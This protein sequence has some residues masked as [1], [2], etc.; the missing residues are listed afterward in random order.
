MSF[1]DEHRWSGKIFTGEWTA[2]DGGTIPV[3]EPATGIEIGRVGEASLGDLQRS[4][5]RAR[6]AQTAWAAVSFTERAAVLRRAAELWTQHSAEV[7][8]WLMREAGGDPSEGA[9]RS[10]WG[11]AG[12]SGV[13]GAAL[14]RAGRGAA[15]RPGT[16][17]HEPAHPGGGGGRHRAVQH[18]AEAGDP[19]GG[20]R[21]GVGQRGDP[22]ARPAH[23][24][25]GWRGAGQGLRGGRAARR[26]AACAARRRR[27]GL[28]DGGPSRRQRGVVHRFHP[29]RPLRR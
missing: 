21:A 13:L 1:L 17:E 6:E 27:A 19:L 10:V 5:A 11:G 24:G 22:Q 12:V 28:S 4:V 7:H 9:V 23:P 18:A 3:V 26:G 14:P 20:A 8:S 25:L 16:V 2:P 29:G 15:H